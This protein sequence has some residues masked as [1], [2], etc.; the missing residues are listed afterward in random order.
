MIESPG[1]P[2]LCNKPTI[3]QTSAARY[4]GSGLLHAR[5]REGRRLRRFIAFVAVIFAWRGLRET[6][7]VNDVLITWQRTGVALAAFFAT[8]P[9]AAQDPVPLPRVVV[10]SIGIDGAD[11]FG[12]PAS[13]SVVDL[14]DTAV[15]VANLGAAVANVPA[16][17]LTA[18]PP[19][20][21]RCSPVPPGA[22]ARSLLPGR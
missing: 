19:A 16:S 22:G 2:R 10:S 9:G 15:P 20:T 13:V 18:R 5:D 21:V 7:P 3:A 12:V 14:D 8:Q 4:S 6:P 11:A 1:E 17:W